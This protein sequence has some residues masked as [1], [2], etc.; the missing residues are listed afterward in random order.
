MSSSQPPFGGEGY[1]WTRY[2]LICPKYPQSLFDT[3]Y[4]YHKQHNGVFDIAHDVGSGCGVV[5]HQLVH[6]FK[7]VYVSEPVPQ[8]IA[9]AHH[10]LSREFDA[11]SV[12]FN[13]I[14][15]EDPWLEE[16]SVDLVTAF[17]C[18]HWSDCSR[19]LPNIARQLKSG[20]TLAALY[21]TP[22]PFLRSNERA[23]RAWRA[24]FDKFAELNYSADSK[25]T[26]SMPGVF[27]GMNT[28]V[29]LDPWLWEKG[30]KR[31]TINAKLLEQSPFHDA[32]EPFRIGDAHRRE[33][34]ESCVGLDDMLES[35]VDEEN[36]STIVDYEWLVEFV[37]SMQPSLPPDVIRDELREVEEAV[38]E[39]GGKTTIVWIVQVLLAT[40]K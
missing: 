25:T 11:G 13:Q 33:G 5:A 31:T 1:D 8:N 23:D 29:R 22:R 10:F 36:W 15:A 21:Y 18:L 32:N 16:S 7:H 12:S 39:E 30:A 37:K 26:K 38:R 40:K 17:E 27:D 14:G 34:V 4:T 20:G 3:I 35:L 9:E 24:I 19:S 28:H 2:I 6:K